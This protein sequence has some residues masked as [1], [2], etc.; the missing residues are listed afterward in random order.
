MRRVY[1]SRQINQDHELASQK[2]LLT[3]KRDHIRFISHELR[4]PL[5]GA[6]L[7]LQVLSNFLSQDDFN[8]TLCDVQLCCT[9]AVDILVSYSNNHDDN[10]VMS[11]I[12]VCLCSFAE[13]SVDIR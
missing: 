2:H 13:R 5:N 9:A 12:F 6:V 3:A 7:G 10:G 8:E 1:L 4:T 11:L